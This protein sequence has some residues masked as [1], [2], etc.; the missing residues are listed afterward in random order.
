MSQ[1]TEAEETELEATGLELGSSPLLGGGQV[2][3]IVENENGRKTIEIGDGTELAVG[4]GEEC[5]L[6]LDDTKVSRRHLILRR[7]GAILTLQDLGSTNGTKLNGMRVGGGERRLVGGDV[8]RA[9]RTTFTVAATANTGV[10]PQEQGRMELELE[11]LEE[12]KLPARLIRIGLPDG[13]SPREMDSLALALNR[14]AVVEERGERRFAALV[15]ASDAPALHDALQKAMPSARVSEARYPDDGRTIA[16]LWLAAAQGDTPYVPRG[17]CVADPGMVKVF[18]VAQRVAQTDT[19]VLITG[20]TGAGKEVLAAQIHR[21]SQRSPKPY[22]RLNCASLPENLLSSELFGHERGAFT[23]ADRRKIGYFEAANGGTLLLDEIGELSPSM[24]VK[25]LRVLENRTV[26]RLGGTTEI[27]VD[28]RVLCAT[29]RDLPEEV[30]AGRFREDL[31]YRV[32][33]FTL[34]VP[35][36]RER[37]AEV[38]MLSELFLRQQA[39]RAGRP[40]PSLGPEATKLLQRHA[41]PGNVRELRNAMEHAFV[42]CDGDVVEPVHLPTTLLE[43]APSSNIPGDIPTDRP[44]SRNVKDRLAAI[45]HASIMEAL[46]AEGGNQTRAAKRLGMSRRAL[47]YKMEKYGIKKKP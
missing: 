45:E 5:E 31:Y 4:R 34:K 39:E 9:G 13:A 38:G 26:L 46:D 15:E 35:P 1:W 28:V 40:A 16:D 27:P 30:K 7:A 20:E 32:S 33:A 36:L 6:T 23:G 22:V 19:T 24:Q 42:L 21:L 11:R 29:H 41:W 12:A 2:F 43:P 44:S 8:I 47:I 25:L 14:V 37:P 10:I 18:R 17:V 3:V